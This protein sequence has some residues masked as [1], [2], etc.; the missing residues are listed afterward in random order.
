M[1]LS[2]GQGDTGVMKVSRENV[3][4][5]SWKSLWPVPFNLLLQLLLTPVGW[6]AYRMAGARTEPWTM[7]EP[8]EPCR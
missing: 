3:Q 2:S 5:P 4:Q 8:W 1:G 7:R 6:D